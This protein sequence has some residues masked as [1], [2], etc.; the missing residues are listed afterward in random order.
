[1][2]VPILARDYRQANPKATMVMRVADG[3]FRRTVARLDVEMRFFRPKRAQNLPQ[4]IN[5]EC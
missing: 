4:E 5:K 1:M 2:P 3:N